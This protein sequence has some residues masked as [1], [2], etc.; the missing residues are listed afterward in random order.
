MKKISSNDKG[1]ATIFL[2]IIVV[3][4]I[5]VAAV[6]AYFVLAGDDDNNDSNK[7]E[8]TVTVNFYVS[9]II[10]TGETIDIFID[11]VKVKT[12]SGISGA[13]TN[14]LSGSEQYKFSGTSK[15]IT[16]SAK[17]MRSNGTDVVQTTSTK[18]TVMSGTASCDANIVFSYTDLKITVGASLAADATLKVYVG[19]NYLAATL[20]YIS[21]GP[22]NY[23]VIDV[24]KIALSDN[25]NTITVRVIA[26]D[27]NNFEK[28]ETVTKDVVKNGTT[29]V[30]IA[31]S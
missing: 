18:I 31:I 1:I 4:V 16:V 30:S 6:G 23:P 20:D 2:V 12:L 17:L 8:T 5:A 24:G 22:T 14:S 15:E 7:N 27:S 21:P 3:A 29:N 25:Q 10:S 28:T 26:T 11:D 13:L 19:S 9:G